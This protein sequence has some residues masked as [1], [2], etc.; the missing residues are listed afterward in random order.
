ML[1]GGWAGRPGEEMKVDMRRRRSNLVGS[2]EG[3]RAQKQDARGE[4][5]QERAWKRRGGSHSSPESEVQPLTA[6][7]RRVLRV[8]QKGL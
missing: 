7:M 6:M 2:R 4:T 3:G 1:G 8:R 5:D